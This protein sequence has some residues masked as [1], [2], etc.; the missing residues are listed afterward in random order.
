[1]VIAAVV[2]LV[3]AV[4]GC[5]GLGML[6]SFSEGSVTSGEPY[7][8]PFVDGSGEPGWPDGPGGFTDEPTETPVVPATTPSAGRGRFTV[9]YE[10]TG[11]GAANVEFYDANGDFLTV[12]GMQPPWR[13]AF[14]A[15]D[16]KQVQ[17]VAIPDDQQRDGV[18]CRITVD[19]KVVSRDSSATGGMASCFGW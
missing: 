5:V 11:T 13:L 6:G 2:A 3:L 1:M 16:R 4:C 7:E 14:T 17:I 19:G 10:I 12:N 9:V 15:N 18:S 8:P